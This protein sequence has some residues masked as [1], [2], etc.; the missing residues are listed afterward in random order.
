MRRLWHRL[1]G[2]VKYSTNNPSVLRIN[3]KGLIRNDD[4]IQ[5]LLSRDLPDDIIRLLELGAADGYRYGS[6]DSLPAEEP[7]KS[8]PDP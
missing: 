1:P 8:V 4:K 2:N 7:P 3:C 5:E 6:E